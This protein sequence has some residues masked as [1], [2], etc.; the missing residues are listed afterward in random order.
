MFAL[1][2]GFAP[3]AAFA[4]FSYSFSV[5]V[6]VSQM[7][8]GWGVIVTCQLFSGPS[9]GGTLVKAVQSS[10]ITGKSSFSEPVPLSTTT[11]TPAGSYRCFLVAA[12]AGGA[13]STLSVAN[14]LGIVIGRS[15]NLA[16]GWRG[17]PAT[18]WVNF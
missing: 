4:D 14:F 2:L 11:T 18:P 7:P 10:P 15:V 1:L 3:I 12:D 8:A 13:G 6:T 9:G 17:T 5:P 16:T